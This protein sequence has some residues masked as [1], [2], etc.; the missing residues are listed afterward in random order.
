MGEI[1]MKKISILL[2]VFLITIALIV[3]FHYTSIQG[4]K[5]P[6]APLSMNPTNTETLND[7]TETLNNPVETIEQHI[8]RLIKINV[9]DDKTKEEAFG[10][11]EDIN[12]VKLNDIDVLAGEKLLDWINKIENISEENM[13]SLFKASKGV[14]GSYAEKYSY[15][16]KLLFLKDKHKFLKCVSLLSTNEA[17]RICSLL[18]YGLSYGNV[19]QEIEAINV[20]VNTEKLTDQEKIVAQKLIESLIKTKG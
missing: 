8:Y 5:L 6:A 9:I 19:D 10:L 14:D 4:H 13:H 7:S 17:D 15:T 16:M 18:A 11:I 1:K 3:G 2:S 12:W 20:I